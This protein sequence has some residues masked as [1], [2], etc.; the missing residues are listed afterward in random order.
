M[1]LKFCFVTLR[2]EGRLRVFRN[3]VLR[4]VFGGKIEKVTGEMVGPIACMRK[5]INTKF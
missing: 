2:E 5:V 3:R 1:G 4:E